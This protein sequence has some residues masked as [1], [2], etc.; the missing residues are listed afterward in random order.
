MRSSVV[1]L[2]AALVVVA[3][4]GGGAV[5]LARHDLPHAPAGAVVTAPGDTVPAVA[6]G[7]TVHFDGSDDP[8]TTFLPLGEQPQDG[9][10]LSAQHAFNA[11]VQKGSKLSPI[12]VS[13]RAYYGSLT[14]RDASPMAAGTRVWGFA[15]VTGCVYAGGPAPPG[16]RPPVRPQH[17]RQWEF[18]DARTGHALGVVEQEVLPD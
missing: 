14:D 12:P 1:G 7:R 16:S 15:V 3:G 9:H 11:L 17:C 10:T 8:S 2:G 13:V 18:V 4:A 5:A 6:A